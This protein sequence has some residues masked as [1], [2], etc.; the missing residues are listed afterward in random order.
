M[1]EQKEHVCPLVVLLGPTAV[2]KTALSVGLA[3]ALDAE[4]ISADSMQFYRHMDIGTAKI[5]REEMQTADGRLIPHHML[6][7]VDPDEPY[8]V[9]DF[10]RDAAGCIRDITARGKL[11]MLVGGSMLY[12]QALTDGYAFDEVAGEDTEL[13]ARLRREYDTLGAA[14]L[15]RRLAETAPEAA[16][17]IAPQDAK[18][19]IRALEV[20]ELT[21][22]PPSAQP[23]AGAPYDVLLLG[24]NREREELYQRIEQRVDI[25]LADGLRQETERLLDMGYAPELKPMQGLGYRQMCQYLGGEV[26]YDE[27]VRLIKRDTRRFAKRQLTWWRR[28]ERICWFRADMMEYGSIVAEMAEMVRR[29]WGDRIG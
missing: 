1:P 25:M 14:V 23:A 12:I 26:T 11:P 27:M 16:A 5:R 21:G 13:R 8:T 15:H 3:A 9:A 10:Q 7:I 18:R 19:L 4:I 20:I 29:R 6:D 2:G 22:K 17:K 24:L 28:D